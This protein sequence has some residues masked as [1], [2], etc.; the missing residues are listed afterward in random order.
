MCVRAAE[1]SRHAATMRALPAL[2]KNT[3]AQDAGEALDTGLVMNFSIFE[4]E[5]FQTWRDSFKGIHATVT[6]YFLH[7]SKKPLAGRILE[8]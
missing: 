7:I 1:Y 6:N 4:G 5:L 8:I 3:A 2:P